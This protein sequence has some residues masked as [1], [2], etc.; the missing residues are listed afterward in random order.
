MPKLGLGLY[1]SLLNGKNFEFAKQAGATH[2]VVQLVDYMKGG[3][4]PSL[5]QNYL[6]GWG[7]TNNQSK[8]WE[9][10]QLIRLKKEIES[11]GLV[12][13]AIENFDPSH[14]FDILLDGPKRLQQMDN[15]KYM[16][17]NIGKAGIP[18]MGYYFS[19]AGVWG[20][21]NRKYGRGNPMTV[22]FDM[23]RVNVNEPIKN[24]MVWNMTYDSTLTGSLG[25]IS[26][27]EMWDRFTWFLNEIIPVAEEN[28]V[29]MVAH[30]DDPPIPEL[31]NA[32]RLFYS[33]EEYE[34]LFSVN[35]SPNNGF[36]FCMGTLQEMPGSNVLETLDKYSSLNRIGYIHFRNVKGKV[37]NYREVFVDEGDLDM[38]EAL[39]ILKKNNF[40]GVLIPDHSPT[41]SCD[42]PWH[43]SM[44]YAMGYMKALID[45]V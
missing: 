43:A 14:W 37:P 13:E 39:R 32:A 18:I 28:G 42:A 44:A 15:L 41:M 35:K 9:Y 5:A 40:E 45:T 2:L 30:P 11:H 20:W 23:D 36:E 26:R 31:R 21:T 27:D 24:G 1:K 22:G 3:D 34:K 12:W 16:I 19:I 4:N 7:V 33:I 8:L 25:P 17:A 6:N 29:K 38:A 10:D